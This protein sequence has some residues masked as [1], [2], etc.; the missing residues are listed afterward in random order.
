MIAHQVLEFGV[1]HF[2]FLQPACFGHVHAAV[3]I[4]PTEKGL[5]AAVVLL[6]HILDRHLA[7][8]DLPQ[9]SEELF[10]AVTLPHVVRLA[11]IR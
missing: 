10:F 4:L 7:G 9:N 2:E 8:L 5:L 1:C 6:A 3:R 11:L